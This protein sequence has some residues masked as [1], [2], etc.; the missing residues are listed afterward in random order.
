MSVDSKFTHLAWVEKELGTLNYPLLSDLSKQVSREYGV[1]L[2]DKGFALRGTFLI[3][4]DGRVRYASVQ[5]TGIGRSV[6]EILRVLRSLK[7]GELCPAEWRPG[8][9]FIPVK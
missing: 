4:P 1:L 3:D 8:R 7:T 2:E 9:P 6:E 5:D